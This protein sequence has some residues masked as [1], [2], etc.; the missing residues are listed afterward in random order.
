M[1]FGPVSRTVTHGKLYL[2]MKCGMRDTDA[3]CGIQVCPRNEV[4]EPVYVVNRR[5]K[6]VASSSKRHVSNIAD[7]ESV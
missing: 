4:D 7:P 2:R 6:L 5:G 1:I 3:G